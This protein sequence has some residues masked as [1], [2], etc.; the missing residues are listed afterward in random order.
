MTTVV[1][2]PMSLSR[3]PTP[4]PPNLSAALYDKGAAQPAASVHKRRIKN[5]PQMR[6]KMTREDK[7]ARATGGKKAK[8]MAEQKG[9]GTKGR[10]NKAS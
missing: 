7:K 8:K 4:E 6:P 3:S 2:E 10:S 1:V 5:K 9:K